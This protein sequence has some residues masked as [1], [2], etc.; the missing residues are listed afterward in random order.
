MVKQAGE[1]LRIQ[2]G[3]EYGFFGEEFN[4]RA[5]DITQI[6]DEEL[7]LIPSHNLDCERIYPLQASIWKLEAKIQIDI[8]KH[9]E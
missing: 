3:R 2:R 8:L 5:A 4:E 9:I 7:E 1:G 6:P